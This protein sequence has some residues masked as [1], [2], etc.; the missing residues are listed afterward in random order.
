MNWEDALAFAVRSRKARSADLEPAS[1]RRFWCSRIL[2]GS[3]FRAVGPFGR[4]RKAPPEVRR[5]RVGDGA[6]RAPPGQ[7]CDFAQITAPR[8][9]APRATKRGAAGARGCFSR[10][11]DLE[12]RNRYLKLVLA[13]RP[14][15]LVETVKVWTRSGR[16][17]RI[18]VVAQGDPGWFTLWWSARGMARAPV[19]LKELQRSRGPV[20]QG[21]RA[22]DRQRVRFRSGRPDYRERIGH[23]ADR[24]QELPVTSGFIRLAVWQWL[25]SP[26]SRG[27]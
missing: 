22:G 8:P 3:P 12:T 7:R 11:L 5:A 1:V 9:T 6:H 2:P 10:L 19:W 18:F 24:N 25:A 14:E 4:T 21:N 26:G 27:R 17:R 15:R 20:P 13:R 16:K 23:P